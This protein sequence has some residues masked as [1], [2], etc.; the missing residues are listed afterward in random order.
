[1]PHNAFRC[2]AVFVFCIAAAACAGPQKPPKDGPVPGA[3]ANVSDGGWIAKPTALLM[4]G[5]D[6]NHDQMTDK[7][8]LLKGAAD[9][10]AA[11]DRDDSGVVSPIELTAWS[12][13]WLGAPYAKPAL[14]DFD[15][16]QDNR[17]SL[18]DYERAFNDVFAG[19]DENKDDVLTREELIVLF[20]PRTQRQSRPEGLAGGGRTPQN[21]GRLPRVSDIEPPADNS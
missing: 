19:F 4:V 5:F 2:F 14:Y 9:A 8:E 20:A 18:R 16:D 3:R 21:G 13:A 10:F 7:A 17:I 6:S 1:M 12:K 15:A 11:A